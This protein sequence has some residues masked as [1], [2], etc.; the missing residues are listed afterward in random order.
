MLRQEVEERVTAARMRI[1]RNGQRFG[2]GV[3]VKGGF[4]LTAA[5]CVPFTS[6]DAQMAKAENQCDYLVTVETNSD[7]QFRMEPL[8]IECL[9]DVAALRR[10]D[11]HNVDH[12]GDRDKFDQVISSIIPLDLW[13]NPPNGN[14]HVLA[15]DDKWIHG[16]LRTSS[17]LSK[18]SITT[19]ERIK[20]ETSGSPIIDD[21][22]R[23]IGVTS[24]AVNSC[25][26]ISPYLGEHPSLVES[27][28]FW[29]LKVIMKKV[30]QPGDES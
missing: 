12:D 6:E 21:E 20:H 14:V 26:A 23:L 5:H 8:V 4:L 15:H 16:R 30:E 25:V 10:I 1:L 7:C 17:S 11:S 18:L 28:P 22:G 13:H 27:L 24:L 2:C 29:I 9:S 3:F 19:N